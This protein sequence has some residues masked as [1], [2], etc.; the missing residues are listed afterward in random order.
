MGSVLHALAPTTVPPDVHHR[1]DGDATFT[2]RFR[3]KSPPPGRVW[4]AQCVPAG[5]SPPV[6]L[7]LSKRGPGRPCRGVRP[8]IISH[9]ELVEACNRAPR[10]LWQEMTGWRQARSRFDRLSVT[11]RAA[12]SGRNR[13]RMCPQAVTGVGRRFDRLSMVPPPS[14]G[15]RCHVMNQ[16]FRRPR[17]FRPHRR[18]GD[19]TATARNVG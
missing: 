14:P 16:W 18:D 3:G 10:A 8:F 9:A 11:V 15:R 12:S 2:S 5:D 17:W 6:T 13:I 1:R 7:S 4:G 19:A